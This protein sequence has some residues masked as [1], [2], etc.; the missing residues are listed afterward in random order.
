[1]AADSPTSLNSYFPQLPEQPFMIESQPV[2][3]KLP[4]TPSAIHCLD[5]DDDGHSAELVTGS[6]PNMSIT[7]ADRYDDHSCYAELVTGSK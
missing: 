4:F 5:S 2:L 3:P 6:I 7:S 1:M